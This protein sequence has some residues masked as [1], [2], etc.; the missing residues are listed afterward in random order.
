MINYIVSLFIKV[1]RTDSKLLHCLYHAQYHSST[2]QTFYNLKFP[3]QN[4]IFERTPFKGTI[5]CFRNTLH[6][7]EL[8]SHL[9]FHQEFRGKI[10]LK[11]VFILYF[12][13]GIS[14]KFRG[15]S[16]HRI[17]NEIFFQLHS[18]RFV[19]IS[20]HKGSQKKAGV[21]RFVDGKVTWL[22]Q[23]I[24]TKPFS[25]VSHSYRFSRVEPYFGKFILIKSENF[26]HLSL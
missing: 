6:R 26:K 20:R 22:L 23:E 11:Y 9:K 2:S 12:F 14:K 15:N 18:D 24:V 25:W 7:S 19:L 16:S 4:L 8:I 21:S 10:F 3:N 17:V 13:H 1:F 5:S